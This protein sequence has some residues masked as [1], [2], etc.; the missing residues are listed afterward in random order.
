MPNLRKKHKIGFDVEMLEKTGS[1]KNTGMADTHL[2]YDD[3]I[4]LIKWMIRLKTQKF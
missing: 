4:S 3:K 1:N 2:H